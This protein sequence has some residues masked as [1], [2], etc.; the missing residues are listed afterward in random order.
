M[1][2][3]LVSATTFY[4]FHK[5]VNEGLV[6]TTISKSKF[7]KL[8]KDGFYYDKDPI[9]IANLCEIKTLPKVDHLDNDDVLLTVDNGVLLIGTKASNY[10]II[11]VLVNGYSLT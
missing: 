1:K 3:V 4:S 6:F 2:V 9:T 8:L 10:K 11:E 5:L 7:C